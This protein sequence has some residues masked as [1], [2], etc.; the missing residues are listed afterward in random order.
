MVLQKVLSQGRSIALQAAI[1][2]SAE[3]HS[4]WFAA[5]LHSIAHGA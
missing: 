3:D 4:N 1:D 5:N 2:R